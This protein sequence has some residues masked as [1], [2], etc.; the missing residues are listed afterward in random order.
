M[1]K[2]TKF[3]NRNVKAPGS[4]GR[5]PCSMREMREMRERETNSADHYLNGQFFDGFVPSRIHLHL[6]DNV[7]GV[8]LL[9]TMQEA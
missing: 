2:L 7:Q 5:D 9:M 3:F 1:C 6:A 4:N 8:E